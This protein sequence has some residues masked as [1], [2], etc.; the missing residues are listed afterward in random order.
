MLNTAGPTH[1]RNVDQSIDAGFDLHESAERGEVP[2]HSL[3]LRARRILRGQRQPRIL[4]GLLHAER[5]L[6]FLL[7]DPQHDALNLVSDRHQ[8]RRMSDIASPAHLGNVDQTLDALLQ[9]DERAVVG[10]RDHAPTHPAPHR[11]L[12]GDVLPR[13]RHQLLEAQ[14]D[15]LTIPV[16]VEDLDLEFLSDVGDLR[17]V[18]DPAPGH[19]GD[20]EE[21]VHASQIDE[22]TE[23]GDVLDDTLPNLAD[24]ELLFQELSLVG[25]L[26]LENHPSGND[27]VPA[28]LVQLQDHEVVLVA[29]QVVHVG[30]PAQRDLRSGQEGIHSHEVH[31]DA[32]LDLTLQH[33]RYGSIVVVRVL[34]LLPDA[35]EVRLLLG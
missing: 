8:L 1:V 21:A 6:L 35:E 26:G 24:L 17:G 16:D 34:D 10:D 4:L 31:R 28:P 13:I 18:P 20:V 7:I 27:D 15:A 19:V 2:H 33:A 9:L 12:G 23:I 29:D 5:D 32:A 25:P 11:V 30:N 14:R 3:D 22:R